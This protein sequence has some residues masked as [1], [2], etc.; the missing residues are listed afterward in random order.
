M[1]NSLFIW[2][3]LSVGSGTRE[4]LVRINFEAKLAKSVPLAAQNQESAKWRSIF[5]EWID[6]EDAK[7]VYHHVL[8]VEYKTLCSF[9]LDNPSRVP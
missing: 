3:C 6:A 7:S 5:G 1:C 8:P 9:P 4:K 2:S